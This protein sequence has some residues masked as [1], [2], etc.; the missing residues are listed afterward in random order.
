MDMTI[1][2]PDISILISIKVQMGLALGLTFALCG[3]AFIEKQNQ[4]GTTERSIALAAPLVVSPPSAAPSNAVRIV[5]LGFAAANNT[6]TLGLFDETVATLGADCR[7]VLV[8]GAEDQFA[9]IAAARRLCAPP[10]SK[11]SNQ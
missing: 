9:R 5:G 3:C 7:V 2:F 1:E 8:G 11:E 6:A 4:D 10:I